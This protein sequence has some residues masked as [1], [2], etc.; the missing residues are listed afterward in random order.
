MAVSSR[1]A[2]ISALYQEMI[3]DHYRRPRNKGELEGA[4]KSVIMKNPLCGDEVTLHV[5]MEGD[6][7][8][9]VRF[10]GRGCSISQ[11]SASMMTQ[12][13]KGKS[14]EEI[15]ELGGKFRDMVMGTADATDEDKSLGSLRSLGGVSKFPA[16]VK[17]ALLAWN[18]LETALDSA[19]A[20]KS[21]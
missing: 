8:S 12:L 1:S 21:R 18:A 6:K 4:T 14:S 16:R 17:C 10:S 2:E 9:D 20:G 13:V 7:V 5:L 11:A 19:A 15:E 3:L